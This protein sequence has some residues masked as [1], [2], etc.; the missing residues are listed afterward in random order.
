MGTLA[1]AR[2]PLGTFQSAPTVRSL[3]PG[4]AEA[5][6]LMTNAMPRTIHWALHPVPSWRR[7][8]MTSRIVGTGTVRGE[9]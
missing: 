1:M 4:V 5:G 9:L 2:A 6:T 8:S 7:D 3:I